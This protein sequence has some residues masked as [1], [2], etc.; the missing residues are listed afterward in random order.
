MREQ[1]LAT[2]PHVPLPATDPLF[3]AD[4]PLMAL[5]R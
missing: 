5:W 3:G 2:I 4:G 1:A